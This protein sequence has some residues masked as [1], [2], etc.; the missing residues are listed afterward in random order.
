MC[1]I[2][3]TCYYRDIKAIVILGK[4]PACLTSRYEEFPKVCIES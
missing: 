1:D 4:R 3:A 2:G